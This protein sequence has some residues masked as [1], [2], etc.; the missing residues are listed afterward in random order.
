MV[1][2]YALLKEGDVIC[3]IDGKSSKIVSITNEH[4]H[5]KTK[6]YN[7]SDI[8]KVNN[9]KLTDYII[10]KTIE[11]LEN[12]SYL[13]ENTINKMFIDCEKKQVTIN[14]SFINDVFYFAEY[15]K[16]NSNIIDMILLYK[17]ANELMR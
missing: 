5:T 3:T 10:E 11:L 8:I 7:L 13:L 17:E 1:N 15:T 6:K 2:T 9:Y 4:I 12:D 16:F 14:T